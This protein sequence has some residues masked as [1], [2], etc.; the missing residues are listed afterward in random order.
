MPHRPRTAVAMRRDWIAAALLG[1][2]TSSWSTLVA[3][4]AATRLGR[5]AWL[6]WM[7]VAAIPMQ[8]AA[9]RAAPDWTVVL[10]GILFHQSADFLWA[11]AFFGLAGRW[12]AGLAP[13]AIAAVALPWAAFTASVEYFVIVPF[14]QPVFVLEQP[15]WIGML[16]H[17]ASASLYPL[18]PWLRDAV[19]RRAHPAHRRFAL[20]WIAGAA[21]VALALGVLAVLGGSGREWPPHAGPA[22]EDA[23]WMR[24]MAAHHR[25]GIAIAGMAEARAADPRL[26][27]LAR[28]MAA[29][30]ASD[31]AVLQQWH[32]GWFGAALPDATPEERAT[33]PGMLGESE[34]AGLAAAKGPAF[35]EA[36]VARMSRHHLGAVAMAD[37]ALHNAADPRLRVMAHALR[38]AQR[39]EIE[40][41]HG[42]TPGLAVVEAAVSAMLD[43]YGEGEAE[44]RAGLQGA[45]AGHSHQSSSAAASSQSRTIAAAPARLRGR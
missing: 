27:S 28:L 33:M 13:R 14:W 35:D 8:Q 31:I 6:D 24:R 43:P 34:M 15:W 19:G 30:Q 10:V 41:M 40:L 29:A 3:Q 2:V 22:A 23:A 7:V 44:A 17:G 26:R 1:V 9:L 39:G 21:A 18:Y 45:A 38:H 36:F 16:V 11:L 25:Q 12:T 5:D 37:W 42:I 32:R 20:R 4:L